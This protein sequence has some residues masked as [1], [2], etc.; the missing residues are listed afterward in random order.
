MY[1]IL[2][3]DLVRAEELRPLQPL[4]DR[5]MAEDDAKWGPRQPRQP[6]ATTIDENK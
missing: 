6:L 5:F 1:F 2:E 4:M 3:F